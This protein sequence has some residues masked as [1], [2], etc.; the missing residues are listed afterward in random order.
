MLAKKTLE[1][2]P[3]HPVMKSLLN[4][5]KESD[6]SLSEASTEYAD[7]MFQM[8]ILN[9]GFA[10]ENP[11]DLTEPLEKLIKVGFGLKRDEPVE[12]IEVE[13]DDEE[14]EDDE[15]NAESTTDGDAKDD[16][17]GDQAEEIDLTSLDEEMEE[18]DPTTE[19]L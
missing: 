9:S 6:G 17:E 18:P 1:L 11:M 8:A 4:E 19:E 14:E 5:L 13:L 7:L 12:E 10:V 16:G 15:E 3:S 2:N